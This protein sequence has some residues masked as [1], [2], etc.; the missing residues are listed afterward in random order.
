M[1]FSGKKEKMKKAYELAYEHDER[2]G[3]CPQCVL[4]AVHEVLNVGDED[5]IKAAHGLAGGGGLALDGTCG[6]LAGGI[7]A[8]SSV[9][10]R[11]RK[12]FGKR[13]CLKSYL[14]AK[15]LHDRF[16]DKYDSPICEKV[17]EKIMGRSFDFWD[18]AQVEEFKKANTGKC[19]DVAGNVAKWTVDILLKEQK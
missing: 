11:E 13:K 1:E 5:L 8:I 4:A 15:E 3:S 18:E 7:I 17:Q 2:Y 10:G 12:D 16:V 9:Y 6:A 19:P 14:L